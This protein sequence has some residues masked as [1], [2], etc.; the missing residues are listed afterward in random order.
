MKPS[1]PAPLR[2]A[3]ARAW[4]PALTALFLTACGGPSGPAGPND[5]GPAGAQ[6]AVFPPPEQLV[7]DRKVEAL[8]TGTLT[9]KPVGAPTARVLG[10]GPTNAPSSIR[11]VF[12]RTM[13]TFDE[14]DLAAEIVSVEP[15]VSGKLRWL[16]ARTLELVPTS[17]FQ[18]ASRVEVKL[19]AA[20]AEDG[21]AATPVTWAFV[22]T[23]LHVALETGSLMYPNAMM[24]DGS[25]ALTASLPI[26]ADAL[27]A[28]LELVD[29]ASKEDL[30]AWPTRGTRTEFA[31]T[32]I[33][34]AGAAPTASA[35]SPAPPG[36]GRLWRVTPQGGFK[37]GHWYRLRVAAEL[38][39]AAGPLPLGSELTAYYRG[40]EPLSVSDVAC[41]WPVCT[42]GDRWVVSFNAEL[43]PSSLAGCLRVAP[44]LDLGEPKVEGWSVVVS[45]K[46]ARVGTEY[47]L[48]VTNRCKSTIGER[49]AT[50][51]E[52]RL[53][54]EEP[55]AS[56]TFPDGTGFLAAQP[57]APPTV[58]IGAAHTGR[59]TIGTGRIDRQALP[60]FLAENLESWGGFSFAT[61]KADKTRVVE[62]RDPEQHIPVALN[63]TL[64]ASGRGLVFLRVEA[65]KNGDSD[66]PPTA[67][68]L[69]QVT[70][71]GLT[72]KSGPRD[73]LVW[74]TSLIDR[75]PLSGVKVEALDAKGQVRWTAE[76][77]ERGMAT[78]AGSAEPTAEGAA[79]V[80]VVSR[81][82]DLAFLD[83]ADW[84]TRSEAYQFGLP[85]GWDSKAE[86]LRGLVFTERGVY[87]AGETVHV[88]GYLRIDRDKRLELATQKTV[89]VRVVNPMGDRA[90]AQTIALGEVGDFEL[91]VALPD[92]APL[93]SWRI[94]A[95]L[96]EGQTTLS[97]A[98][99][100]EAYRP[101]TF[102]VKIDTLEQAGAN[103]TASVSGRYYYGAPMPGATLRWNVVRADA[104]FRPAGYEDYS[105][106]V[107]SWSSSNWEPE[108]ESVAPTSSDETQLDAQGQ[109]AL[110]IAL[111]PLLGQTVNGPQTLTLEAEVADVDQQ[112]VTSR[113]SVRV[114]SSDFYFGIK[115]ST[116]FAGVGDPVDVDVVAIRP[117]GTPVDRAT[118]DVRWI[119]RTWETSRV[120]AAGGGE[121]WE[122]K[123][124]ED[125]ETMTPG[126]VEGKNT[127]KGR[128]SAASSGLYWV[129]VE[130]KDST[131]RV[132][133]AR[134]EVWVWGDGAS[135][136]ASDEG[137]VE[138]VAEKPTWKV[139]DTAR[140]VVQSPF[141]AG[142]E[143][144]VTVERTGV[145]WKTTMHV[146][147][148]AP[149][150]EIPVTADMQP[151]AYVSVVLIGSDTR[152]AP[153]DLL[154]DAR[155]GYQRLAVDTSDRALTVTVLADHPS[156]LPRDKATIKLKVTDAEGRPAPG[157]ATFMAVD[158][159]VLSLTGY[160]TPDPIAAF[161]AER[162]LS[163][164]TT[165]SRRQLWSRLVAEAGM[166]SDWGGGGEGGEA[167]NY[168]S[169]F[170]TTAAFLPKVEVGPS[171][172]AELAFDLPDNLT[173]F[174][175]MAVAATV[176]GR[177]GSGESR[178]EVRK[179]L[180]VRPGLP[181]FLSVG[182]SFDAR[183]I[184]QRLDPELP[185]D[186]EVD[187]QVS[188]PVT[189]TGP[190]TQPLQATA[191]ATPVSFKVNATGPGTATFAFRVK[192]KGAAANTK[193]SD[194]VEVQIPVHWP[195]AT[196]SAFATGV[197]PAATSTTQ[198]ELRIP[199]W[200]REDVGGIDITLTAS[201][202]GDLLP[203]LEYLVEY[204][205]GCVE[206]TTGGTL[207]LLALREL[208]GGF[209]LPGIDKDAVLKRAQAGIDRLRMMQTWTGGIGYWP[210]ETAPHPWGS[211][212]AGLALVRASKMEGLEVSP[213][214]LERLLAYLRDILR[215]QAAAARDEW[216]SEI[217]VVKP[218]AAY[219]LA[220]AGTPEPSYHASLFQGRDKLPD[221]GKLLLALAID[222]A[223]GDR[224]MALTLLD[225][226]LKTVKVDGESAR[227]IRDNNRYWSS[228]M[229]SDVRS[230]ALAAIA[231]ETLR[232]GDALLP[233]LQK[234]LLD[235]RQGGHW[236]TT[237]DNAFAIL[238]LAHTFLRT[239]KPGAT[240]TAKVDVDGQTWLEQAMRADD[241]APVTVHLPMQVVRQFAG[242]TMTLRRTGDEA[243]VYWTM[244]FD[245][246]PAE[247]QRRPIGHGLRVERRYLFANG[248]RAGQPLTEVKAGD[249][250]RVEVTVEANEPRRYVAV[251]DPL[252]ATLEPVTLD[253]A[254]TSAALGALAQGAS[255]DG[256]DA[257]AY[258]RVEQRDDRVALFSDVMDAGRHTHVYLAR[259]TSVGAFTAPA[260]RAYEMYHPEVYGQSEALDLSVKPAL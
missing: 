242:K 83:L 235:A 178:L 145:L 127:F 213:A 2:S 150:I 181:R 63:D 5:A 59:L 180:L 74:V 164:T 9:D 57:D 191:K 247:V 66:E 115:T 163:I 126:K 207:P 43:D 232:P 197:L 52:R 13:R 29:G 149:L 218:F 233:K 249:L 155:L 156:Y 252:P 140:F 157:F 31:L 104:N 80:I 86:E 208:Q 136:S 30:V 141:A 189:L 226:V 25:I 146:S 27:R 128:F 105:F 58:E 98:F 78:G 28:A 215:D 61:A 7:D 68:A 240:F 203:G 92:T 243:P 51:F 204:P 81:G 36:S 198:T 230:M 34:D 184:V 139:G 138:I 214:A 174:R 45:P 102:E 231:L 154:G 250:V 39:A 67:Q 162:P 1:P 179:P 18:P 192:P 10:I 110:S 21:T 89:D 238:A 158:E 170:A 3:P 109:A 228:T 14:R 210:G 120:A 79:R 201:R 169:A 116:S 142:A 64:G 62:P 121:T 258:N 165:E 107:P 99:R 95:S 152:S 220:L 20:Q 97:G 16:D 114:E 75:K 26:Q 15:S 217:E 166:K 37:V 117:D 177:F 47:R 237:Q 111:A 133:K 256:W 187:L 234:G 254:T 130:G 24:P 244:R 260:A 186:V 251:E 216:H 253:F 12:D 131:G 125:L 219:V 8:A 17:P 199:E 227:L 4:Y 132:V 159:G 77:D 241:P 200:V 72:V 76:T 96:S 84:R 185:A 42:P 205:H 161:Y 176:D 259:A 134:S 175:L 222:A 71:L 224:Q 223:K 50:P 100:V 246:A 91:D 56:L 229:D 173:S 40:P 73:T 151:N 137:H 55:R 65:Q 147:G 49:L 90:S 70:E 221:F 46:G 211:A 196:R 122:S 88:K 112:V 123:A 236:G 202:L 255:R 48:T 168:R 6:V 193:A 183:A 248:E 44:A 190:T 167:S 23:P 19:L 239:E 32:E 124:R 60:T 245:Y 54:I 153:S 106:E 93:G 82:E 85:H 33:T 129:E 35:D 53:R 113:R 41:G 172:E 144:L 182:D 212:Y 101:N 257:S 69:I 188:G 209:A 11:F 160:K 103:L 148:S 135:W 22:S 87:R 94:E 206:Q 194:A 225:D 195:A 119:R 108:G 38:R 143:A 171:G 118:F